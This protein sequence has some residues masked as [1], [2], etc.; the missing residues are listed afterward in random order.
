ML[1]DSVDRGGPHRNLLQAAWQGCS[2]L[3]KKILVSDILLYNIFVKDITVMCR[4]VT[5]TPRMN[6]RETRKVSATRSGSPMSGSLTK[7][8]ADPV[9]RPLPPQEPASS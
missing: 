9:P 1:L 3:V 8:K 5:L 4:G 2:R 7:V 6:M